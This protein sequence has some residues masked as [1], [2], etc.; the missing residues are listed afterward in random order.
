MHAKELRN[1]EKPKPTEEEIEDDPLV[2]DLSDHIGT[3]KWGKVHFSFAPQDPTV[4]IRIPKKFVDLAKQM[5]KKKGVKY[6]RMMRDAIV[7]YVV[8][9]A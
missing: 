8:K 2:E 6:H 1:R 7:D 4:T 5:A 9:A 3:L